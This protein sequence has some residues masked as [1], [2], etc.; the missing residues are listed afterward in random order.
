M[1][2]NHSTIQIV[3][4]YHLNCS[5]YNLNRKSTISLSRCSKKKAQV[6]KR[7]AFFT[8]NNTKRTNLVIYRV[9]IK[10]STFLPRVDSVGVDNEVSVNLTNFKTVLKRQSGRA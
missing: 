1:V 7:K 9:I 8:V 4:L 3:K 6:S 10:Y 2:L 5:H